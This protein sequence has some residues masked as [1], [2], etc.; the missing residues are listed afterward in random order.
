MVEESDHLQEAKVLVDETVQIMNNNVRVLFEREAKLNELNDRAEDLQGSALHFQM[1]SR[2]LR[3][4]FWWENFV[5]ISI[6]CVLLFI[7]IVS[8]IIWVTESEE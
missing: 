1:Q 6:I 4:K 5:F 2:K 7:L 3:S 8:V